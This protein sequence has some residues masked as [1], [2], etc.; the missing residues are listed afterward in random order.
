MANEGEGKTPQI[1]EIVLQN[2]ENREENEKLFYKILKIERRKRNCSTKSWKSRGEREIVLQNWKLKGEREV[3]YKT[4]PRGEREMIFQKLENWGENETWKFI[5]PAWEGKPR[6]I[7]LQEFLEIGTLYKKELNLTNILTILNFR[8]NLILNFLQLLK[9][10]TIFLYFFL[11]N[12]NFFLTIWTISFYSF[13]QLIY[14]H[15]WQIWLFFTMLMIFL[16]KFNNFWKF[17]SFFITVDNCDNLFYQFDNWRD[18]PIHLQD[19]RHWFQFLYL[20][21]I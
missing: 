3:R 1:S 17:Q 19:L 14:Y 8:K 7:S 20:G 11:A 21:M 12:L 5:S 13:W 4:E 15:S 10:L 2:L 16:D 9:I 18:N 6:G